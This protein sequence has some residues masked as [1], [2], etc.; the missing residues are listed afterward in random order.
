[1]Y[2]EV[3]IRRSGINKHTDTY[4]PYGRFVVFVH[5]CV[6]TEAKNSERIE[7]KFLLQTALDLAHV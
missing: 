1:M 4:T 7:Q 2:T 3:F 5:A 6:E